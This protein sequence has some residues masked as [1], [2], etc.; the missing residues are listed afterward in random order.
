[1]PLNTGVIPAVSSTLL[2]DNEGKISVAE[3]PEL[4]SSFLAT[5]DL[6]LPAA[7]PPGV[8]G[9]RVCTGHVRCETEPQRAGRR[10][11]LSA[12]GGAGGRAGGHCQQRSGGERTSQAPRP[13]TRGRAWW[14]GQSLPLP[15]GG[16]QVQCG[17]SLAKCR[18]FVQM[19]EPM[20]AGY[21]QTGNSVDWFPYRTGSE[22][23]CSRTPARLPPSR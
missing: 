7:L 3:V 10:G 13:S 19:G 8:R 4:G 1:M 11:S 5:G 23:S 12:W 20:R 14:G 2:G 15:L 9:H 17:C 22:N 6:L 21:K 18:W 16:A